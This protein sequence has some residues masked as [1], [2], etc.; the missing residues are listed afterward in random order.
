MTL[1]QRFKKH[2]KKLIC[3]LLGHDRIYLV[4]TEHGKPNDN[5]IYKQTGTWNCYR[6]GK[7]GKGF[8]SQ[9]EVR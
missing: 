4:Q 5:F 3:F 2:F 1:K 9:F 8:R 7:F 6:C